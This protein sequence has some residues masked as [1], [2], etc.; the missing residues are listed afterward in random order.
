MSVSKWAYNPDVCDGE[1]CVGDC[2]YCRIAEE[3]EEAE[4]ADED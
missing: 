2:D 3:S 4:E 1:P